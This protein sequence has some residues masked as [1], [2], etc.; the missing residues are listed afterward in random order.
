MNIYETSLRYVLMQVFG[1]TLVFILYL[2]LYLRIFWNHD[3]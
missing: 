3:N 2:Y 1:C